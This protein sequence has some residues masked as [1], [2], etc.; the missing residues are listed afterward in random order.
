VLQKTKEHQLYGNSKKC[1]FWLEQVVFL[2]HAIAKE[3]MKL[4]P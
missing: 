2:G 4:N 1:E 3:G